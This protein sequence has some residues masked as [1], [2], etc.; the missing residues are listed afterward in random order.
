MRNRMEF[1]REQ[2]E[3]YAITDRTWLEGRAL[4]EQVEKA[5]KGGATMV[6]L[7]EKHLQR[8]KFLV[9]AKE[10]LPLCHRYQVPLIVNDDVA[11]AKEVGA[12]GVHIGQGDMPIS[13]A[14]RILG[15]DA[16][17]G[18]TAKTIEQARAAEAAGATYLGSGAVFGTSTKADASPMLLDLFQEI[19]TSVSIPVVAIGGINFG[20]LSSLKGR[21]MAGIAVVS[22]IFASHDIE[23]ETKRLRQKM[24]D[25]LEKHI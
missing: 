16:I 2:L 3:L 15:D 14:R 9:E 6:Q 11:L 10:M 25:I 7:R 5:L 1:K 8:D 19:C 12:D 22:G 4:T 18:V 24:D 13:E 20:N 17:I 21:K 23:A